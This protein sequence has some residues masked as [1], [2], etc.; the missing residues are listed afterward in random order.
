MAFIVNPVNGGLS[1]TFQWQFSPD[2]VS[3]FTDISGATASTYNST[4]LS[5]GS[6]IRVVM[7]SNATCTSGNPATSSHVTMTVNPNV[8]P[9]ISIIES[10]NPVCAGQTVS[11]SIES[12]QN[13]GIAP[14]YQWQSR[15]NSTGTW[16]D[17]SGATGTTYS[18]SALADG[19]Q[20]RLLINSSVPCAANPAT[21]NPIT[22][23]LYPDPTVTTSLT[24][25]VYCN[26]VVTS[27]I[28]LTGTPSGVIFDISGGSA[29][30]L[31]NQT[32][33]TSIPAFIPITGLATITVTPRANNCTGEPV[34][35]NITVNPTPVVNSP[36]NLAFCNG[37]LT[38]PLQLTGSPEGV[39]F[40]IS[41]GASIGLSDQVGV[42]EI[43]AFTPVTG[44]AL[45]TII[46]K[47]NGCA[48]VPINFTIT[49][50]PT[51]TA[52]A[53]ND[54]VYCNGVATSPIN[55]AGTPLGVVFDIAG[56][57]GIGLADR[58]GVTAI[59]SFTPVTGSATITIT[60][61]AN[62]CT[63]T[64]VTF[65][66]L[67][68]PTPT[69]TAPPDQIYC[70]G[71]TTT[72][73]PLTGS[74]AGVVF[75]ITGGASIGLP[76]RTGVTEIPSF[77]ASRGN[78]TV[79]ITPR[80]NGCTGSSVSFIVTVNENLPVG[81]SITASANPICVG[82]Q[83]TFTAMPLNGGS[84]PS[85]QWRV[86]G[87]PAGANSP[88]F[89]YTPVNGDVINVSL[90][91]NLQCTTGNPATS[92]SIVMTVF[93]SAPATPGIISGP[94][95]ICPVA[96]DLV[97][98][99]ESVPN[100]TSYTWAVPSG[101]SFTGQGT[102]SINAIA[103]STAV[104]GNIT[105]RANNVCGT[106]VASILPVSVGNFAYAFAGP[107]QTV[108]AGTTTI[109]LQGEVGGVITRANQWD[110]LSSVP[111]GTFSGG[112]NDLTGTYTIPLSVRNGGTVIITLVTIDPPGLC[113]FV[114]D[115]M[116]LTIRPNPTASISVTGANPIC[117]GSSSQVTFTAT[118]NTTV[119][120]RVN[121]GADQTIQVGE[122]GT[123]ILPTGNLTTTTTYSLVSVAYSTP[124]ACS[125]TATGTA[126][127]TVNPVAVVNA[128]ADQTVCATNPVVTLAGSI[129]GG[130]TTGTWNGGTG[131]F[132]PNRT[133]LNATYTPS[134]AEITA[135]TLTL[136]LTSDDPEGPCG[137]ESDQMVITINQAATVEAGEPQTICAGS[138]ATLNGSIGGS[139]TSATWSGGTGT[140]LPNAS[141]LNAVY[142]PGA[143]DVAAGTV[144]LTLTTNDPGGPCGFVTDQ[145][146]I[147]INPQ[148]T[149]N[150]G[151]D[152]TICG[153]SAVTL[154]G[155]FGG[156]A[157]SAT[158][159]GGT[160]TFSDNTNLNA[161][162]TPG[163]ADITAGSVILTLTTNDPDGPCPAV[164][165][166]V[167]V[168]INTQPTVNAGAD[169][170][171][172]E[173][174]SVTLAGSVG[175]SATSGTWSGGA[176]TFNPNSNTLTAT[177]TPHAD[178]ITAGSVTL[179]L[180]TNDPA[181]VCSAVMDDVTIT[182]N[183]RATANAGTYSPI[184]S[185]G[186]VTLAGEVGGGAT[187]GSWTGGTGT[188]NPDRNS[189]TAIYTPRPAEI[190]ARSVTLTLTKD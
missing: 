114:S 90:T 54:Q 183:P 42:N 123:A 111:G 60:P 93:T 179:T 15:P 68:N 78:A 115:E 117:S 44:N 185:D 64:P 163:T 19:N 120:Y 91:S 116:I 16:M 4:T 57:A 139:A 132:S 180:T 92:N 186:S 109:N 124:P 100:S 172:C 178:E 14:T 99:I 36:G 40:D 98:T 96:T 142:N 136:T 122:S 33:V 119:T 110:W 166:Q 87:T 31:A 49:V 3:P 128:G 56:G 154:N 83:V 167:V 77:T 23:E 103:G 62:N 130:V 69:A 145:V 150:A 177:Y 148:A 43:Q 146:V 35:Y 97:Y 30:G 113:N 138:T 2:V 66:I 17:I 73:I 131:I 184:C 164:S 8:T 63:G 161:V 79:T 86:N 152:Q 38:S 104:G 45:I 88:T 181:G 112:G 67:V 27:A 171:I 12:E 11:F 141:T 85:Y 137:P 160:G 95:A 118:P 1:P 41:G 129:T 25:Q 151:S 80:A 48:G 127:V 46:P 158:W 106:S 76:D 162:Y 187:S 13:G 74:P 190:A 34:R 188:F 82:T 21:S 39:V 20:V 59:P 58:T 89:N 81:V 159:S 176:G 126:T 26:G 165:D 51:P 147:T 140:F 125:Q 144:T 168:T 84:A 102:L 71:Q 133:T 50:H 175:G 94:D 101:W 189:L 182:I 7:T 157:T 70:D 61:R 24:D 53:P 173:G 28:N 169:Q 32:G 9:S 105:V 47:A 22:V 75:D 153:G 65:N 170:T 134:Q 135:G 121:G 29:I 156:S 52:T 155:T 6:R 5:N 10:A 72:L 143:A 18:S 37:V 149:V 174:S 55:L 108:C 107:D